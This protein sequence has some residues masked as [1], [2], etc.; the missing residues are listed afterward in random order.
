VF[1]M[2]QTAHAA[3]LTRAKGEHRGP[4]PIISGESSK[5]AEFPPLPTVYPSLD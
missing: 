1:A 3:I 2:S 5:G 4:P